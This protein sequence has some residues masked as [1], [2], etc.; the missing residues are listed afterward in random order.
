MGASYSNAT[1]VGIPI[2]LYALGEEALLPL[3]IIVSV[4]NLVLF[5]VGI[6]V[7]QRDSLSLSSF[8]GDF[9][10]IVRQLLS[11]PIT[12]SLILGGMVN[13]LDIPIYKPLVEA[14]TL[15]SSAAV[16]SALFVLGCSL[17][18]YKIQGHLAPALTIVALKTLCFPL[19]VWLLLF[20]VFD[21]STLWAGTALLTSAMPV[22]ISA[23]IFSKKYSLYEAPIAT[24]IVLSTLASLLS[25]SVVIAYLQSLQ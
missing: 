11:S 24:S 12:A 1:I 14:I 25:L 4:H 8:L 21:I 16:P 20:Q 17:N 6:F 23:Y 18:R 7:A 2:C 5:T 19:L 9:F 22:G 13:L 15:L 3:F 10:V